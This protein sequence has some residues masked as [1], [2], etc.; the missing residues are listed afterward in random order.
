MKDKYNKKTVITPKS[1]GN[2]DVIN[3]IVH[4]NLTDTGIQVD[5]DTGIQKP[6]EK[7][8][9]KATF[10]LDVALHKRLRTFAVLNDTTMLV[11]VEKAINE[12]LERMEK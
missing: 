5:V 3:K 10:E 7:K 11:V 8:I 9:K 1:K 2:R 4:N 12:Y 6:V